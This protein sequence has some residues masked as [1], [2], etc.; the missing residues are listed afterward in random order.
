MGSMPGRTDPLS[1]KACCTASPASRAREIIGVRGRG[2]PPGEPPEHGRVPVRK[3]GR[4]RE[5]LCTVARDPYRIRRGH[6]LVRG[7]RAVGRHVRV[8]VKLS[9][10]AFAGTAAVGSGRSPAR[11]WSTYAIHTP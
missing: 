5:A 6:P 3:A 9:G 4:S 7:G 1:S 10:E 8:V 11:A 2:A